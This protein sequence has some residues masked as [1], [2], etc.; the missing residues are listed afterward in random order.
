[1]VRYLAG[2]MDG[3]LYD[4]KTGQWIYKVETATDSTFSVTSESQQVTGGKTNS[5]IGTFYHSKK[6][7]LKMT[8]A[9]FNL[10]LL[11]L[12]GG[13]D[14]EYS[15]DII[16][17]ESVILDANGIGTIVGDPVEFLGKYQGTAVLAKEKEDGEYKQIEIDPL[18]KQ[19]TFPDGQDGDEVCVTYFIT[20]DDVRMTR[21]MTA[22]SPK[23]LYFYGTSNIYEDNE[24]VGI[25]HYKIPRYAL[26]DGFELALTSSGVASF[27]LD[28]EAHV[29]KD[30]SCNG[31]EDYYVELVEEIFNKKWYDTATE[32]ATVSA[33]ELLVGEEETVEVTAIQTDAQVATIVKPKYLTFEIPSTGQAICTVDATGKLTAVSV[34]TTDL[35][36][37]VTAK[38][39]LT[40]TIPIT[41]L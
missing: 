41:V 35:K 21:I 36:I 31:G 33:V 7:S 16:T 2:A 5:A 13:S 30:P 4:P 38:P 20:N 32:I 1:M 39:E 24:I 15:A 11:A 25:Q 18:T 27:S 34:G 17:S 14:I 26:L 40:V 10:S 37:T 29:V 8:V 28:G 19:F 6:V 9:E 23:T 22:C 12:K 3:T